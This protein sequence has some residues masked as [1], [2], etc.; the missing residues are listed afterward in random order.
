MALDAW[1]PHR[2]LSHEAGSSWYPFVMR[3]KLSCWP[4]TERTML[5][6]QDGWAFN[7]AVRFQEA[8]C[9]L[10]ETDEQVFWSSY[11]LLACLI[12]RARTDMTFLEALEALAIAHLYGG[13]T[14]SQVTQQFR[15]LEV[16]P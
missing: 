4:E 13:L 2:E 12:E 7:A 14:V 11:Y 10:A 6:G 15:S 3:L 16:W 8:A 1:R 5:R 9:K